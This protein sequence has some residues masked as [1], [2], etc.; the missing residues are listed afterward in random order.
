MQAFVIYL[1]FSFGLTLKICF[2]CFLDKSIK[3]FKITP[4]AQGAT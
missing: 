1:L 3:S 4:K 2:V